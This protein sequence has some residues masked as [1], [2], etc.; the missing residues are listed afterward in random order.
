MSYQ[1][2]ESGS[3]SASALSE[4]NDAND[5]FDL[6]AFLS[7]VQ[8]S[9]VDILP[10]PWQPEA[11]LL[12]QGGSAIISQ[13]QVSEDTNF[14]FKRTENVK[15]LVKRTAAESLMQN[16]SITDTNISQAEARY[17]SEMPRFQTLI[18]ELLVL[19]HT[20]VRDHPNI[21]DVNAICWGVDRTT[22]EVWPVLVFPKSELGDLQHFM[23]SEQGLQMN[24]MERIKLCLGILEAVSVLH[25][26]GETTHHYVD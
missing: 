1:S 8:A 22:H 7:A 20:A 12:G 10:I 5:H 24:P 19:R 15:P 25:K 4:K 9:Q 26:N 21:I 3:T 18:T 13:S 14:A 23:N 16:L 11:P 2:Y 17:D 6:I